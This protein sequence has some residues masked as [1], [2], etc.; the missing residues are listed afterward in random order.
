MAKKGV[1]YE[2]PPKKFGVPADYIPLREYGGPLIGAVHKE[3]K[4][5]PYNVAAKKQGGGR[6]RK[7]SG[8]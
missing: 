1:T 3:V 8:N 7:P 6:K 4:M 2:N 5:R